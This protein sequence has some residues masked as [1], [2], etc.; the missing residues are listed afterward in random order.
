MH[1]PNAVP[2]LLGLP[3]LVESDMSPGLEA[4]MSRNAFR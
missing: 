2:P 3:P 1:P 4:D